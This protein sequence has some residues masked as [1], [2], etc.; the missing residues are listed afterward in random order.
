MIKLDG[1]A[2]ADAAATIARQQAEI[3]HLQR[4]VSDDRFAQDLRDALTMA[5]A[6]GTIGA[7]VNHARLLKMIVAT[8]ADIIEAIAASLFLIDAEEQNLVFKVLFVGNDF[9][10]C[11]EFRIPLGEGVAGLVA[12]T[13]ESLAI[14]DTAEDDIDDVDFARVPLGYTPK[15]VLC[16]P[17]SFEDRVIGVLQFLDKEGDATFDAD[18]MEAVA[19]F[20]NLA[21]VALE[22][23]RTHTRMG[24]LLAQLVEGLDGV[25]DYDRDGLTERARLFTAELGQQTGYINA[26]VLARL[27]GEIIQHGDAAADACKGVLN[28]FVEFLRSSPMSIDAEDGAS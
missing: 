28:S 8:A 15:N 18:D 5:S 3:E 1:G 10:E 22:Q 26:L 23:S 25:P 6:T 4:R 21:A 24:A 2:P 16:V 17:L 11:E 20:A 19:L 14:S 27:V 9:R 7:P 13:G 12:S